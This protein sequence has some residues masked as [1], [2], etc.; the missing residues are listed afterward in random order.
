M[1]V[2]F[3]SEY[4]ILMRQKYCLKLSTFAAWLTLAGYAAAIRAWGAI[5]TAKFN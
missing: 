2:N 5:F 4:F 3:K 1:E